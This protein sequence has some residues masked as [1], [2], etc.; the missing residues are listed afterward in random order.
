MALGTVPLVNACEHW[1][2]FRE[3]CRVCAWWGC[4]ADFGVVTPCCISF[5]R[6]GA[7]IGVVPKSAFTA[8]WLKTANV[9]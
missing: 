5:G 3:P 1:I 9:N 6:E 7:L 4:V 8:G 2:L